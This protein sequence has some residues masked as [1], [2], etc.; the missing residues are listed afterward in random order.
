MSDSE[1]VRV[2][3]WL[4][5]VRVFK[6]RSQAAE[7]C[8]KSRVLI[9]GDAVKPGKSINVGTIIDVKK[10]P[11]I[12]TY[13]VLAL[14]EKRMGAKLVKDYMEDLTPEEELAKIDMMRFNIDGY[15]Q[16]GK[17]RPTKKERRELDDFKGKK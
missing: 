11:L 9:D 3:K 8:K 1:A 4:W 12:H 13:K 15:R 7:A 16:R 5:A 17:G 10:P 2:D 14:A 6:T